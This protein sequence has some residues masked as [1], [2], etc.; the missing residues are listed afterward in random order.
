MKGDRASDGEL[1]LFR[2]TSGSARVVIPRDLCRAGAS[3]L[4]TLAPRDPRLRARPW[5]LQP[6]LRTLVSIK[7]EIGHLCHDENKPGKQN[8]AQSQTAMAPHAMPVGVSPGMSSIL[9]GHPHVCPARRATLHFLR[10]A[11]HACQLALPPP[12]TR[13]VVCGS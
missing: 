11:E 12:S 7:R 3:S 6:F 13:A 9:F 5:K 1:L 2:L 8:S 10:A 4:L